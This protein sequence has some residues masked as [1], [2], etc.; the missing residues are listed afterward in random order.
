MFRT[1]LLL[2]FLA[3]SLSA[4]AAAHRD[5]VARLRITDPMIASGAPALRGALTL[6]T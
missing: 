5:P 6:V 4:C 3:A 1:H 2:G